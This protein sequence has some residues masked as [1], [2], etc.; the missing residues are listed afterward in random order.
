MCIQCVYMKTVLNVKTDKETK[1]KAQ[2]IA[3]EIGLPLSTVV[4]GLLNEFIINKEIRFSVPYQM[5]PKLERLLGRVEKDLKTGKNISPVFS[6]PEEA[7]RY[8]H[9]K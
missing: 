7:I 3:K 5:S 2:Q 6:D 1:R 4:T 8:L 9:S